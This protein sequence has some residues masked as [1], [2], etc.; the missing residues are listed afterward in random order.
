MPVRSH[1]GTRLVELKGWVFPARRRRVAGLVPLGGINLKKTNE[2]L[3]GLSLGR[4][5]FCGT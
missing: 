2:I 1:G 3:E 4:H 5:F